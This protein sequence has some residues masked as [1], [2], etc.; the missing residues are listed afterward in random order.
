M[1]LEHDWAHYF[2]NA[3]KEGE[4][5]E[6]E[7]K[8]AAWKTLLDHYGYGVTSPVDA[9]VGRAVQRGY[10]DRCTLA[11]LAQ[12]L[13]ASSEAQAAQAKYH[14]AWTKFWHSLNGNGEQLLRELRDITIGAIDVIGPG[15]LQPAYEVFSQAGQTEIAEELLE[16][17]IASN[18]H[19]PAVFGQ[20]DGAFRDMYSGAFADRLRKESERHKARPSVEEALDRIDFERGWNPEDIRVVGN[21]DPD[22]IERLLRNSEGHRFRARLL[23]LLRIGSLQDAQEGEKRVSEQTLELLKRLASEDPITAIRL[24]QYIPADAAGEKS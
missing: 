14:E 5:T 1:K 13:S 7:R 16:R 10:F 15:D 18:Q 19:R 17:F 21:A 4:E 11:P 22:E 6:E 20:V 3:K 12:Q 2:R 23:T 8:L 24:R 9:E